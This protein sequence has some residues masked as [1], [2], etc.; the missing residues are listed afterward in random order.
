MLKRIFLKHVVLTFFTGTFLTKQPPHLRLTLSLH[1]TQV[2]RLFF[3]EE[4]TMFMDDSIW[5]QGH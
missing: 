1:S 2:C 4:N 3:S 5:T